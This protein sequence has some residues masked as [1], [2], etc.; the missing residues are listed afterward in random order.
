MGKEKT[1][2]IIFNLKLFLFILFAFM[3]IIIQQTQRYFLLA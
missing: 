3:R 1:S 2:I